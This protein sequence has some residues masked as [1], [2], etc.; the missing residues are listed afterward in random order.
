MLGSLGSLV[1]VFV[2]VYLVYRV[3]Q[4]YRYTKSLE[5]TLGEQTR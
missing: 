5:K 3:W 1:L 4:H 2:P